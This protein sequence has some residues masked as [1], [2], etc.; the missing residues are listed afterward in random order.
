MLFATSLGTFATGFSFTD[1]GGRIGVVNTIDSPLVVTSKNDPNPAQF[2][3]AK[4]TKT[5]L[6]FDGDVLSH[7][8]VFDVDLYSDPAFTYFKLAVLGQF[9]YQDFRHLWLMPKVSFGLVCGTPGRPEVP[10]WQPKDYVGCT[11]DNLATC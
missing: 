11:P 4:W 9:V 3:N 8:F 1:G 2:K 7:R 6:H 10:V 5:S